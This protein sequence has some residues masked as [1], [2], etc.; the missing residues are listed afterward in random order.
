M[1][2]LRSWLGSAYWPL[3]SVH[4]GMGHR[5]SRRMWAHLAL[6]S[7]SR[8]S[9]RETRGKTY[10]QRRPC[11]SAAS[12]S[13]SL[14]DRRRNRTC[15]ASARRWVWL[16]TIEQYDAATYACC[17]IWIRRDGS[18]R[19]AAAAGNWVVAFRPGGRSSW[20][21]LQPYSRRSCRPCS[22]C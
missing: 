13:C 22:S 18:W 19:M 15:L 16:S 5:V 20:R 3:H 8:G 17:S 6:S 4:P 2:M 7:S 9:S 1:P 10:E 14:P 21:L 11:H 12:W